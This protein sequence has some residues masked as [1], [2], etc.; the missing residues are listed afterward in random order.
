MLLSMFFA[1]IFGVKINLFMSFLYLVINT[2]VFCG[3]TDAAK[4]KHQIVIVLIVG[5]VITLPI[6]NA[7]GI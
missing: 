7:N 1:G 3:L 2:I 6:L 4:K 5:I